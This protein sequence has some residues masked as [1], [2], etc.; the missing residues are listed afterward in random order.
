MQKHR[1]K[2]IGAC[3]VLFRNT[4]LF[5]NTVTVKNNELTLNVRSTQNTLRILSGALAP[6]N[7][8]ISLICSTVKRTTHG[9]WPDVNDTWRTNSLL[10]TSEHN[11]CISSAKLL[12][13]CLCSA[14]RFDVTLTLMFWICF[15][16]RGH[17]IG[18]NCWVYIWSRA[19][20]R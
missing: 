6:Q 7:C 3:I 14:M 17:E 5:L 12:V 1:T 16:L 20:L 19:L 8:F 18:H 10:G 15:K 13:P 9:A 11:V 4:E 2:K